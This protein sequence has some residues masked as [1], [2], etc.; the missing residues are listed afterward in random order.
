MKTRYLLPL[1]ALLWAGFVYPI[2][3]EPAASDGPMS[4]VAPND[5]AV[6]VFLRPSKLGKAI[7]FYVMDENKQFL[8]M[9]RGNQNTGV[10][11]PPGKR[12]IYVVSENAEL[13]RAELAAGR[14]Y[15]IVARAKMGFGKA[16]VEVETVRRNTPSFA[17]SATWI[18]DTKAADP[19]LDDGAKWVRKHESAIAKRI[20]NAEAEWSSGGENYRAAHSL[21]VEDGRTQDEAGAL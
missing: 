6:V 4:Y 17:E 18:R 15:I 14:T 5:K 2:A 11:V 10:A 9:F 16:R 20:G 13:V 3:T 12:T 21:G 19:D 8:T 7:N 1:L